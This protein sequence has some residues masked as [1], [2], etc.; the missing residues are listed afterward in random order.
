MLVK[1]WDAF[2]S[3]MVACGILEAPINALHGLFEKRDGAGR[4]VRSKDSAFV[5]APQEAVGRWGLE[6]RVPRMAL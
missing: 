2:E 4:S 3:L 1:C 5:S 6:R